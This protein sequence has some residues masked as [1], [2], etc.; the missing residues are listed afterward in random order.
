MAQRENL[1]LP[2][3]ARWPKD[4]PVI[5]VRHAAKRFG[6]LQVLTDVNLTVET[7]KTTVIAGESGSGKSVLLR[8]MNGLTIPDA[9]EVFLFGRNLAQ[10]SERERTELRKR[11]TMVFQNY[12]LID[13]FTVLENIAFPLRENTKMSD[14]DIRKRVMELLEL[15]ELPHAVN[16]FPASLSGGMKKRVAFARAVVTNPEVVLFDEPTTGLDP[17]M[18]DF[19]D[20]LILKTRD[21]FD[22]TSVIVS[23]DMHSNQ[24]L[25]DKMAMLA[26]GRIVEQGTY[27]EVCRSKEPSIQAFLAQATQKQSSNTVDVTIEN[28]KETLKAEA[29]AVEIQG[30]HKYFGTNHVL[31]GIDLTIPDKKI[32]VVIGGSGSGKSV[33]IKHISGLFKP[34]QGK[35]FVLGKCLNDLSGGELRDLQSRVGLLFQGAALFDSMTIFENLAFPLVEGR[36]MNAKSVKPMVEAVAERLKIQDILKRFP[37]EVSN[38]ERKRVGLGRALITQPEIMIY[39]E[40]TTG[41]DPVMMQRVDDMIVETQAMFPITSIVISH[42]MASTFRIAD[43]IAMIDKGNLAL[44]GTPDEFRASQDPR[45][46]RFIHAG[47]PSYN[48]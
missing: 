17:I 41:Q 3:V 16:E 18:I 1:L 31:K 30:V 39:D 7:S 24:R 43:K 5:E 44:A 34:D 35:V 22:L 42:D 2:G 46:Q 19:V 12:A 10:I 8:L 32:T 14:K 37:A 9:G 13:S 45:V 29:S 28:Q 4:Q 26:Q 38:G 21:E 40:P 6:D 25:A 23:H 36:R 20:G 27:E 33:L 11:C 47:Q 48:A 15:L